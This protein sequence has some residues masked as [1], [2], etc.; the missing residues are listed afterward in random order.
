M[1]KRRLSKQQVERIRERQSKKLDSKTQSRHQEDDTLGPERPGLVI[2]HHGKQV[3]VEAL[4]SL[5]QPTAEAPQ[6][7]RCHLRAT[8]GSVVTGDRI[9]F[10]EGDSSGIIVAIQPRKSTLVRPDSYGKLKP[11][12]ANVDQLLIT[13]ACAPEPFS[14]LI[15][16]YLAV[17]ENLHIRPVLLFNK[18]DLLQR[19]DACV[20][21]VKKV[22]HLRSLYTSLGYTCIDTCAKNGDGLDTL[23]ETLKNNTSV[24]VGQSGV[25]KSSLIKKL[26]PDED[27]AIGALSEAIDK[28]RH[29]TTHSELFHF[30]FGGDCIDSPGIREFGLWHLTPEEV[31]YGFIDVRELAGNCKF[32]DCS[33]LREPK[34]AVLEALEEGTL[35]ADRYDNYQRI[36]QSLD[37]V[38]MQG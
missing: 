5:N 16:R 15:D 13:I 2:A 23:R 38:D 35:N 18:L 25:G 27:I 8:L 11:V 19:D 1:A 28:G 9:I 37:D 34:C 31:T 6:R 22:Q 20:S 3:Q 32:R 17:A 33:H 12:A 30:P 7:L 4:D 14:G 21:I 36:V 24:F 10:Q 26:L 29:T